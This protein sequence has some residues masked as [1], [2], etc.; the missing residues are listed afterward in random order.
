MNHKAYGDCE[1]P[2][3]FPMQAEAAST[4]EKLLSAN[5]GAEYTRATMEKTDTELLTGERADVSW[6]QTEA[7][8]RQQEIL[9][10]AGFHDEVYAKNPIV[11]LNHSYYMPP[12]GRSA[13]RQ[14]V[15]E[16]GRR[17][18]KAKTLYPEREASWPTEEPWPSDPA[19]ALVKAGLMNGKSVGF[20]SL[21]SR[22]PTEEEIKRNPELARVRRIIEE[23]LL[24]EYACCWQPVNSE[25]V[26]EATSK[27]RSKD[28]DLFGIKPLEPA[29]R[30]ISMTPLGEIAKAFQRRITGLDA[31]AL[32]KEV[33]L[34]QLEVAKG[35]V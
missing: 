11:T 17:G 15:R 4:L 30:R 28:L 33:L 22:Q 20:V 35:R 9:L 24:V 34:R 19:W 3:G 14:R 6:I 10:A 32:T 23:W 21:K 27:S 25:A 31:A 12:I 8:D 5:P 2:L 29:T 1:G 16:N 7:V 26:V 13:W 18:V